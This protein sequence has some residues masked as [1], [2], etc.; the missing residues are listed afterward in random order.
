MG[1]ILCFF[2]NV[3]TNLNVDNFY[4]KR[5]SIWSPLWCVFNTR[6]DTKSPGLELDKR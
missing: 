3:P 1:T 4:P 5:L 6:E 2:D